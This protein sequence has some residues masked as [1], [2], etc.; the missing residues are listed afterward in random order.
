MARLVT[1]EFAQELDADLLRPALLVKAEFKNG[2]LCLWTGNK[3]IS[4]NGD[5][6][7]GAGQLL[8]ISGISE[9]QKLQANNLVFSLSAMPTS[10]ISIALSEEYQWQPISMWFAVLDKNFNLINDPY[11]I[12]AGKMDVLEISDDGETGSITIS[13]ENN[14]ISLKDAKERRYTQEDQMAYFPGDKGLEFMPTNSDLEITWGAGV[15]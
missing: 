4:F 3:D 12:F 8:G 1:N 2:D 14:L 5:N 10:L 6:Y 9:T 7:I 13:A 15:K 11:L